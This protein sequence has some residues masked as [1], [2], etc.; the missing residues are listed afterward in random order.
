MGKID[1][2]RIMKDIAKL[3][4]GRNEEVFSL[5]KFF[6]S[7]ENAPVIREMGSQL[8]KN[9]RMA[10]RNNPITIAMRYE[11]LCLSAIFSLNCRRGIV[12]NS[13]FIYS[14]KTAVTIFP[15]SF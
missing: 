3:L 8:L 9:S 15:F 13:C 7:V 11:F 6:Q 1:D 5:E 12:I 14:C 4:Y 2:N 10:Y